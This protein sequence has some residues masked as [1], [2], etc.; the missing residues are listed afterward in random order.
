MD[1]TSWAS[2]WAF[3]SLLIFLGILV[4]V[5]VPSMIGKSLDKRAADIS[6]ELDQAKKLREEAQ[7]LLAE[8][9]RKRNEAEKEAASILSSAEKEAAQLREEARI[10]TEDYVARRTALAEQKIRQAETEAVNEVRASAVELAV[11]A[12]EKLVAEK[13]DTAKAGDLFQSSLG[14]L[15]TRLN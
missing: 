12:A 15:K 7:Q 6:N 11:A 4:Y 1:A 10:K 3:V 5:K 2:L 9:Q 14:E 8:Y 13:V